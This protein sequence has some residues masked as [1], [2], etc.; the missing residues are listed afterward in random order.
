MARQRL[1]LAVI[2]SL[3]IVLHNLLEFKAQNSESAEPSETEST[4]AG[5][6]EFTL[7]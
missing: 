7:P 6:T 4:L 3:I 5:L 2:G 1:A